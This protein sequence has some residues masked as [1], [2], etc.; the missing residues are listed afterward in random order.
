V[1]ICGDLIN[2]AGNPAQAAGILIVGKPIA[3]S[4]PAW[5]GHDVGNRPPVSLAAYRENSRRLLASS[6]DLEVSC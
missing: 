4:T 3:P 1:V 6:Q 2:Q 5:L